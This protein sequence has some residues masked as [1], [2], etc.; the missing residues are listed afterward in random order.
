MRSTR[1]AG[2]SGAV[3]IL[4]LDLSLERNQD[5]LL[6][7]R[8]RRMRRAPRPQDG[9]MTG[10]LFDIGSPASKRR[11]R[12]ETARG[13]AGR[14]VKAMDHRSEHRGVTF[15][16]QKAAEERAAAEQGSRGTYR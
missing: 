11:K 3:A 9:G 8:V 16:A 2:S 15:S 5:L 4:E 14:E 10:Q 6:G 13:A 12:L 1:G 7:M